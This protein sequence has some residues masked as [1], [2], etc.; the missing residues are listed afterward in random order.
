MIAGRLI[1]VCNAFQQTHRMSDN[2]QRINALASG[3]SFS[4]QN[5]PTKQAE[6]LCRFEQ[7][8]LVPYHPGLALRLVPFAFATGKPAPTRQ[9]FY[10]GLG[11]MDGLGVRAAAGLNSWH[12]RRVS[13][14]SE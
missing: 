2:L 11:G 3:P 7:S 9:S 13:R 5:D 8:V 4:S 1:Q 6:K 10:A 14:A 12:G